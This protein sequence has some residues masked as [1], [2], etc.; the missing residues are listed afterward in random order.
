MGHET[1]DVDLPRCEPFGVSKSGCSLPHEVDRRAERDRTPLEPCLLEAFRAE[2]RHRLGEVPLMP[3]SQA[4][5]QRR[6]NRLELP[7]C[8]AE[9]AGGAVGVAPGE[10][11]VCSALEYD[12][13]KPAVAELEEEHQRLLEVGSRR[14]VVAAFAGEVAEGPQALGGVTA[15]AEIAQ[16]SEAL[17]EQRTSRLELAAGDRDHGEIDACERDA[18]RVADLAERFE[19]LLEQ[20]ASPFVLLDEPGEDPA[21]VECASEPFAVAKGLTDRE[22]I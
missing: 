6:S 2:I 16:R 11:G 17:V 4:S 22:D 15:V 20:C 3:G 8:R 7:A 19:T 13:G 21:P 10:G 14:L 12:R 18:R 5:G 9:Q 1:Q